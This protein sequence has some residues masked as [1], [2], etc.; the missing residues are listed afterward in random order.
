MVVLLSIVGP[1]SAVRGVLLSCPLDAFVHRPF[2]KVGKHREGTLQAA[3]ARLSSPEFKRGGVCA[4]DA[5]G[6]CS[7]AALDYFKRDYVFGHGALRDFKFAS[8]SV[9]GITC[10]FTSR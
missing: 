5:T 3:L 6:V 7:S 1:L 8:R 4:A 2:R 9:S 10:K